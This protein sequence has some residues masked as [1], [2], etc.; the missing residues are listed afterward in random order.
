[1]YPAPWQI[2][3]PPTPTML[4]RRRHFFP[5]DRML[6]LFCISNWR[7]AE[8]AQ[9]TDAERLRAASKLR[10]R[11]YIKPLLQCRDLFIL[12]TDRTQHLFERADQFLDHPLAFI[13]ICRQ[14]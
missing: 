5:C 6:F 2:L 9:L 13:K 1:D 12:L 11:Q 4:T 10:T 8:Q 3:G 7:L 14:I